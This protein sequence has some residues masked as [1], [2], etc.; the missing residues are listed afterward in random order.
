MNYEHTGSN[1]GQG[2][3]KLLLGHFKGRDKLSFF[4][5]FHIGN[6]LLRLVTL[7]VT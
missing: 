3:Q 2:K 1:V 5:Y 7:E 6:G 4:V